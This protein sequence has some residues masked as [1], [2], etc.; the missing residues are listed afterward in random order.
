MKTKIYS[1]K[2]D[3]KVINNQVFRLKNMVICTTI[4]NTITNQLFY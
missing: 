1:R 4:S 3:K 2:L